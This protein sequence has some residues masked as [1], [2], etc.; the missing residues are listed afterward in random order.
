MDK[1]MCMSGPKSDAHDG[2]QLTWGKRPHFSCVSPVA[3][4]LDPPDSVATK[5]LAATLVLAYGA[6]D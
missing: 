5:G 3:I 6:N 1:S 2:S 4:G